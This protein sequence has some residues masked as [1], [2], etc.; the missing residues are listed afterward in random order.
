M[1][2]SSGGMCVDCDMLDHT[3][4]QQAEQNKI[5][6][7]RALDAERRKKREMDS[8]RYW[9]HSN[10][11]RHKVTM[12]IFGETGWCSGDIHTHTIQYKYT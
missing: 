3:T 4:T 2:N 11:E 5:Y 10:E 6:V 12:E 1:G 9:K 8:D 7:L